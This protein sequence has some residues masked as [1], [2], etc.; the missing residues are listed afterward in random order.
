MSRLRGLPIWVWL[1]FGAAGLV[2]GVIGTW[3][4]ARAVDDYIAAN[5]AFWTN[6]YKLPAP[7]DG[8]N[9]QAILGAI[10]QVTGCG[11]AAVASLVR[12]MTTARRWLV[13]RGLVAALFAF[14]LIE[15]GLRGYFQ[16]VVNTLCMDCAEPPPDPPW[17]AFSAGAS[18]LTAT[19]AVSFLIGVT[20]V[21]VA[22]VRPRRVPI[23][24]ANP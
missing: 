21:T 19:A 23:T 16:L 15:I 6:L 12:L 20:L 22:V 3:V 7:S 10:M 18:A 11:M 4:Y 17:S 13:L 24:V 1:A 5:P 14:L 2:L 8:E 9:R